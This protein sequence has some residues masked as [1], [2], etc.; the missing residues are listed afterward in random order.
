MGQLS[1][2]DVSPLLRQFTKFGKQWKH[3]A[4]RKAFR[5]KLT[6]EKI[7]NPAHRLPVFQVFRLRFYQQKDRLR[8]RTQFWAGDGNTL[9][10]I[11]MLIA[12]TFAEKHKKTRV[13]R[14]KK[15]SRSDEAD[16]RCTNTQQSQIWKCEP[17]PMTITLL[18]F[19]QHVAC[20]YYT[21]LLSVLTAKTRR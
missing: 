12:I 4:S 5:W 1:A 13:I 20:W 15:A 21:T 17:W 2:S 19:I 8:W 6:F 7:C 16:R 11:T 3:S 18:Y 9:T 10:V 14:Q